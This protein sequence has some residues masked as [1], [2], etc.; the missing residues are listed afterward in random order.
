LPDLSQL[1][2]FEKT[3]EQRFDDWKVSSGG[4]HVLRD[5]YAMA[6]RYANE[7]KRTGVKA[8]IKML[9]EL[10]RHRIKH[11]RSRAQRMGRKIGKSNGYT[12]NNDFTALVARHI[13]E[14]REDWKGMFET[15]ERNVKRGGPKLAVI[16]PMKKGT[17]DADTNS[18][19]V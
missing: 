19:E 2:L 10:E 15:R 13:E 11:V 8:S 9:W 18:S 3:V 6:A 1:E 12:L 16:L 17:P 4:N 7:W 5:L 14:H